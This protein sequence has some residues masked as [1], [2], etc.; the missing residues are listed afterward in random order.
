MAH[1]ARP[2]LIG[3]QKT[4]FWELKQQRHCPP[5]VVSSWEAGVEIAGDRVEVV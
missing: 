3:K 1:A 2:Q 5:Q 4:S